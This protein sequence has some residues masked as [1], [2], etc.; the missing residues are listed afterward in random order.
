MSWLGLFFSGQE[1]ILGE[2]PKWGF[3]SETW[4]LVD[5]KRW[6]CKMLCFSCSAEGGGK[7]W[8]SFADFWLLHLLWVSPEMRWGLST[9]KVTLSCFFW[10]FPS[11]LLLLLAF[12]VTYICLC[13]KPSARNVTA[14]PWL[15]CLPHPSNLPSR[16]CSFPCILSDTINH[17][18][19]PWTGDFSLP[20]YQGGASVM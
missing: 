13:F 2:I 8:C 20:L 16:C 3:V 1:R 17:K 4:L 15:P 7:V 6:D 19:S 18:N 10:N 5:I 14:L 9:V 12:P 11:I